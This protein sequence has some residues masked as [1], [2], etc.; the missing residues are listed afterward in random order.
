MNQITLGLSDLRV[1]RMAYGCMRIAGTWNPAEVDADRRNHAYECINAAV[2]AGYNFFD[3]A[4]IYCRGECERIFGEVMAAQPGLRDR[5][6]IATKCGIRQPGEPHPDSPH[7][8]DFSKEHIIW[9]C[10]QSLK[11]LQT[12]V[13]DL[14]QLHR[15]DALMNPHEI[16]E[17]FLKLHEQGKVR[18]FGVSNFYPSTVS[19][20]QSGLPFPLIV[21]QIEV[22]LRRLAPIYDGTLD[23]CIEKKIV[24]LSWSPLGGGRFVRDSDSPEVR[25]H[26]EKLME[27][28]NT[29][30]EK[31]ET[32]WAVIAT[33]WLMK[34]PSGIIPI[35]GSANPDRIR[36]SVKADAI[37][38]D[39]EDWYRIFV[40][41]RMERL[42]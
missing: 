18:W 41:A 13:I 26:A 20:L 27:V 22:H 10:E 35:I 7:R 34:H 23:Q 29:V 1:T 8:Y 17:A 15:P 5:V 33:A 16:G 19:A 28:L 42:P 14:Y 36:E 38:L 21:N 11:K 30:A 25:Q 24:P 12:D 31:F 3:H 2:D 32:T 37:E 6:I 39:R 40:A 4:D 9:S